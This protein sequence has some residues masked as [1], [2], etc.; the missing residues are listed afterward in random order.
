MDDRPTALRDDARRLGVS[1]D[2]RQVGQL[3]RFVRLL[4]RWGTVYNLSAVRGEGAILQLHVLDSLAAVA[5]LAR[6]AGGRPLEIL[7]AGSG[8]GLPGAV[9]AVA[10]SDWVVTT[11]DAVAKKVAFV[12]QVAAELEL[13]NLRPLH[14]RVEALPAEARFDVVISRAFAPLAEFV[15]AT[16]DRL[17][18]GGVWVAMK[19]L[20]ADQEIAALPGT[21]AVFHVEPLQVPRLDAARCLVWIRPH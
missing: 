7:D 8:A 20:R 10:R 12:R 15:A 2:D 9:L 5:P 21:V 3:L 4:E 18:T 11:V 13:G 17:K 14:G 16:N 6:W 1:L 19:G